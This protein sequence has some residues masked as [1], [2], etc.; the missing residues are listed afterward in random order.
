MGIPLK[1][2]L[3]SRDQDYLAR[4]QATPAEQTRD[5]CVGYDDTGDRA[6]ITVPA[7]QWQRS[8]DDG[9]D[10]ND[11][12]TDISEDGGPTYIYTP[13]SADDVGK[14]LRATLTFGMLEATATTPVFGPVAAGTDTAPEPEITY[15]IGTSQ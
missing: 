11:T 13:T 9:D 12:W 2:N 5:S 8:T 4:I 6:G 3:D 7:W 14:C 15:D 1:I 10:S